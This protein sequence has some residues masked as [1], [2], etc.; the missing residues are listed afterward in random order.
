MSDDNGEG[1]IDVLLATEQTFEPPPEFAAQANASDPA[2][3]E[4]ANEDPEAWWGS[5]AEKLDWIEPWDEILD[6]SDPP[7]AKWFLSLIHI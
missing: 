5:W 6:W 2:I 7:F 4:R 3:Y 1:K